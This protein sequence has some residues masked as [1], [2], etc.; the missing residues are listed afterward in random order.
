MASTFS[1]NN[2]SKSIITL[3]A[4]A[5]LIILPQITR[6][7]HFDNEAEEWHTPDTIDI[8]QGEL[9]E[10]LSTSSDSVNVL[11]IMNKKG[12]VE[13]TLK[14]SGIRSFVTIRLKS[15]QRIYGKVVHITDSTLVM[16]NRNTVRFKNIKW[17]KIYNLPLRLIRTIG[18]A[19]I[20]GVGLPLFAVSVAGGVILISTGFA[21]PGIILGGIGAVFGAGMTWGGI[22]LV[23]TE[24]YNFTTKHKYAVK[25]QKPKSLIKSY[26]NL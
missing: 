3:A 20:I 24:K 26:L 25:K 6:A 19:A 16:R 4:L 9:D 2:F 12:D 23:H 22:E 1:F 10:I 18:G 17:I 5:L 8:D 11:V 15:G 21:G 13:E 7:E 14:G